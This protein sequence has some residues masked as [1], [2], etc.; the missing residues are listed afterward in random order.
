[1]GNGKNLIKKKEQQ[2]EEQIISFIKKRI[3]ILNISIFLL[4]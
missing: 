4:F 2:K 3:N 1:M